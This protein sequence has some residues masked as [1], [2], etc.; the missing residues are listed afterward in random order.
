MAEDLTEPEA[1]S[2][3][4]AVPA[5]PEQ[6]VTSGSN[7]KFGISAFFLMVSLKFEYLLLAL[8][9]FES[10]FEVLLNMN[11]AFSLFES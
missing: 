6:P 1:E 2:S 4:A 11:T 5:V 10:M 3:P 7:F 8:L 9:L